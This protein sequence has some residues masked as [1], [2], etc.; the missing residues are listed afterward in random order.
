M[1]SRSSPAAVKA[2]LK[3]DGV[4]PDQQHQ[5][6]LAAACRDSREDGRRSPGCP[7]ARTSRHRPRR[8][9]RAD[10]G[11]RRGPR[12]GARRS[13][14]PRSSSGGC[15]ARWRTTQRGPQ[16]TVRGLAG[17]EHPRG[18]LAALVQRRVDVRHP[19]VDARG[20]DLADGGDVP[21]GH[22]VDDA[23]ARSARR[24]PW[25]PARAVHRRRRAPAAAPC[26]ARRRGVDLLGRQLRAALAGG[27]EDPGRALERYHQ[28]DIQRVTGPVSPGRRAGQTPSRS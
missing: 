1:R 8:P 6:G 7:A 26:P 9:V 14:R 16:L 25:P 17:E 23:P 11:G 15:P 12:S 20:D 3:S 2:R 5:H 10:S 27:A 19:A 22:R 18:A 21:S 4:L 28:G 24:P 13:R